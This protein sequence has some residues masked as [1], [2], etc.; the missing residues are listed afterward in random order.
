MTKKKKIALICLSAAL[1]VSMGVGV[2]LAYLGQIRQK[3]NKI[4][5]GL[6]DVSIQEEFESID[7]QETENVNRKKIQVK[8]TGST[9]CYVRVFAEFSDSRA[10]KLAKVTSSETAPAKES[11]MWYSWDN[12]R[13]ET[14]NEDNTVS[15]GWVYV[16]DS[17]K[18]SGYF[19]YKT[20]LAPGEV[21][22]E[23]LITW[24]LTDFDGTRTDSNPDLIRSFDITVYSETVQA[25]EITADGTKTE[26]TDWRNA[27]QS[28]LIR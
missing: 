1:V 3:S 24:V 15:P 19:Y 12:F 13:L 8:N 6:G 14:Q 27:W 5:V 26:Y 10:A 28:F 21:T 20:K 4:E 11:N 7:I 23:P 18:L 25:T 16:S 22:K 9:P 2:T 17:T